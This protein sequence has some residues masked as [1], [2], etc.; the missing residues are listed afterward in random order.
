MAWTAPVK[1]GDFELPPEDTHVARCYRIVDLG[2]SL[3][4]RYGKKQHKIIVGWELPYALMKDGDMAGRPFSIHQR[5]TF[6]M[7]PKANLRADLESWRGKK[8]TDE[9]AEA[10]DISAVIGKPCMIGV[11]HNNGYANVSS[12]IKVP[13]GIDCPPQIN[14]PLLFVLTPERFSQTIFDKLSDKLKETIT[15]SDEYQEIVHGVKEE[16]KGAP[17][18]DDFDDDIPF[19]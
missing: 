10:F 3:N 14:E 5:Y 4:E 19:N 13:H 6:S 12:I 16:R 8:M 17:P 18:I 9:D 2:T 11:V 15:K 7:S 1:G